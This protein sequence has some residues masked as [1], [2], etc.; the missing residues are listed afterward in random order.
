MNRLIYA[1]HIIL[2][3]ILGIGCTTVQIE[4]QPRIPETNAQSPKY[5]TDESILKRIGQLEERLRDQ[6]DHIATLLE[7]SGLYQDIGDKKNA[8]IYMEQLKALGFVDDPRLYGSLGKI[9]KREGRYQQALINFRLFKSLLPESSPTILKVDQEIRQ[10]EFIIQSLDSPKDI[11][12]KPLGKSINTDSYEYLP[13]FTMDNS[14]LIFTRRFF[15]QEDLFEA[16]FND[17]V[18]EVTPLEEINTLENEGAHSLSADG[19]TLILT[20]CH[21]RKGFGNCDLYRSKK[22]SS[23]KWSKPSNL[24]QRLNT[25]HWDSQPSLSADGR[26]LYFASKREGGYGGSDLWV[27]Y[28][29]SDGRWS[30]PKNLGSEINTTGNEE[31]PFIHADGKTLYF[32]STAHQNLGNFDLFRSEK[33]KEGWTKPMNLGSPIN[34]TGAEGALVVSLDGMTGYYASDMIDGQKRNQTDIFKFELPKDLRPAPMTFVKGRI[35][36]RVSG[37]PLPAEI[38]IASINNDQFRS[39]YK[40]NLNGEFLAAIPMGEQVLIN[41]SSED[42]AFYSDHYF[43]PELK[44]G[45]EPYLLNVALDQL[46]LT[47][48][49]ERSEPI[50]LTNIFFKTGSSE[51]TENSRGEILILFGLLQENDDL[52]IEISGHT[53]NIGNVSDNLELSLKRAESVKLTLTEKGIDPERIIAIG[54]GET[55]PVASNETSEG[56]AQNRRTE[57]VIIK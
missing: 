49:I 47:E 25:R 30:V 6:P 15:G 29:R 31:S 39:I 12:L 34:T 9:Y 4:P 48:E 18:Y 37:M 2:I 14:T 54:K 50:I 33:T 24:G 8:L 19:N 43:Y 26:T 17:T 10:L 27:S 56:R 32:R 28:Q 41:V 22:I 23:G 20:Q 57:F 52:R 53:D 7:L 40:T 35:I 21:E 51:L 3:A 44:Y 1:F 13:Q 55:E 42:Y 11:Q 16:R 38:R 46:Q 45:V 5:Q 36:D